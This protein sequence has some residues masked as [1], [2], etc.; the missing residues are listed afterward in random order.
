MTQTLRDAYLNPVTHDFEFDAQGSVV[1]V[2]GVELLAQRVRERLSTITGE[3]LLST[4]VGVPW[5]TDVLGKSSG[6]VVQAVIRACIIGTPGVVEI[7]DLTLE[8]DAPRRI[9]SVTF[10]CRGVILSGD[11]VTFNGTAS[12]PVPA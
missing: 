11:T 6:N 5:L 4:D 9:L 10:S 8:A 1:M 7:L 12:V 3:L 2:E